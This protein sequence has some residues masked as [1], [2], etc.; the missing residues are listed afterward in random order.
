VHG[1]PLRRVPANLAADATSSNTAT[2]RLV[3][4]LHGLCETD[5]CW[6]FAAEKRWGD[7]TCTYGSRLG[8]DDGW[9]PVY[10]NFNTG[11]RVSDNGRELADQAGGPRRT[12]P[13]RSP[14]SPSSAIARRA[15]RA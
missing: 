10:V 6:S 14:R 2:G 8:A 12:W 3:L 4:F 9:T 5:L 15:G 1:G 13:S 7:R 11:K